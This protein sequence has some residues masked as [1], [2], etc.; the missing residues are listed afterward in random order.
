VVEELQEQLLAR[1]EELTRR[2][3]ALGAW[4]KSIGVSK[5]ALVKVSQD[6]DMEQVKTEATRLEY[7]KKMRT[8]TTHVKH[9][10]VLNK[11]LGMDKVMFTEMERD[12]KLSE[13]V[14][15]EV[16]AWGLNPRDNQEHLMELFKLRKRLDEVEVVRF[17]EVRQLAVLVEDISKALVDLGLPPSQGSPRT[18]LGPGTS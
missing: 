5:R 7:L 11:M 8:H 10:L 16:E 3:E 4:E 6:L 12:L 1:E 17:A 18:W 15:A 2:M 14:L 9:T 13:E